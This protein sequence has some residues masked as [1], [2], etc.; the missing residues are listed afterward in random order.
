MLIVI[1]L[2]FFMAMWCF[3]QTAFTDPGEVPTFWGFRK[4]D[5]V[6]RRKRY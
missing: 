1:H 3:F 2:M 6:S 5:P 4:G